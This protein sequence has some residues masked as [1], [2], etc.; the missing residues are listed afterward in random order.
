MLKLSRITKRFGS[1]TVVN[2]VDLV[3][4]EART[5]ALIGPSGCGKSTLLRIMIG[6]ISPDEGRVELDGRSLSD[7]KLGQARAKFGYVIQSGGLFPHMTARENATLP[8]VY[9]KWSR[10]Q[11]SARLEELRQLAGLAE[12]TLDRFPAQLSG[13]Q[14]QRVSLMRALML[15]PDILL[16]DEPLAALDPMIRSQLRRQLKRIFQSLRKTVVIVTHDLYEAAWFGDRIALMKAGGLV[17]TG[18]I[19]DLRERPSSDFVTS[20]IAAQ[21][22][23]HSPAGR[24]TDGGAP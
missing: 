20:F 6:L 8:A 22:H 17:Q 18:T 5:L 13:G 15:D 12:G 1:Q 23:Y 24:S 10:P 2:G 11:I 16:L 3:L 4:E 9:R 14:R 19:D 21:Q 7:V